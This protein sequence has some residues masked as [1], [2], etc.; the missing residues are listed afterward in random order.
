M[1]GVEQ[2]CRALRATIVGLGAACAALIGLGIGGDGPYAVHAEEAKTPPPV[3]GSLITTSPDD[4]KLTWG[5]CPD[6][7]RRAARSRC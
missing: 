4:P 5:A 6:I 1:V 2:V 7:F 3:T